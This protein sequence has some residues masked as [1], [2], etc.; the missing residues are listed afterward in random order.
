MS[1][2]RQVYHGP[3]TRGEDAPASRSEDVWLGW[4]RCRT[5][6]EVAAAL[7]LALDDA[8]PTWTLWKL[9]GGWSRTA[10]GPESP[11]RVSPGRARVASLEA[12]W[13]ERRDR[14]EGGRR[15]S[16]GGDDSGRV[17]WVLDLPDE[18][19]RTS[20]IERQWPH[21][22]AALDRARR[23][24]ALERLSTIDAATGLYNARHLEAVLKREVSRAER[25]GGD[26]C[27]LFLDLDHFKDVNDQL[28][29]PTGTLLLRD[30]GKLLLAC[31][32]Q[33]DYAFRYG[34]DEFAVLLVEATKASA[35]RVA[36]RI[37]RS[38]VAHGRR[39]ADARRGVTASI[40]V[41]TFPSD[42]ASVEALLSRADAAMYAAKERG[43]NTVYTLDLP[44]RVETVGL[45][46]A[47]GASVGTVTADVDQPILLWDVMGTL[48]TEPFVEAVPQHFGV[49]LE[50]L[51]R[52]KD[53]HAWIRFE[54]GE[55]DEDE[56]CASFFRDRRPVD[57]LGLKA[58]MQGAYDF[59]PGVPELLAAL[60]G[61]SVPMYAL[62]NYSPW[63][64]LI[65]E[66]LEISR[67]VSWDFVSC[68]TGYRK[69]EPEAYA[70]VLERLGV[71]AERCVF[72][73]DRMKNVE[74][75]RRMGMQAI[76][77]PEDPIRLIDALVRCGIP[78]PGR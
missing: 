53:P 67:W 42:A 38:I 47:P 7:G 8:L 34:G 43:R 26:L 58:A 78:V 48:V 33:T 73:D 31:I 3:V 44:T 75:A 66:K 36:D 52:E 49:S 18:P 63:Y 29:H 28:G 5:A 68:H 41:A 2:G 64:A 65:E 69:P 71:V 19:E 13:S 12:V 61:A 56:Y 39:F 40:G 4:A 30:I 72:V 32:R 6:G 46:G 74:G 10:G 1:T 55:I 70:V 54:R 77:R 22:V 14:V 50:Q 16:F 24:E 20:S 25:F 62:S 27:L 59:L 57:K 35:T 76:L 21:V 9:E 45:A 17:A 60:Q 15:F 23:F 11:S 37:R 51:L